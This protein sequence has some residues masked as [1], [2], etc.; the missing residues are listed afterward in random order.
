MVGVARGNGHRAAE[1][2]LDAGLNQVLIAV[3]EYRQ[4]HAGGI[5]VNQLS[6][7]RGPSRRDQSPAD[8]GAAQL[9]ADGGHD[10]G[11]PPT[12]AATIGETVAIG[13]LNARGQDDALELARSEEHTSE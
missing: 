9:G 10:H 2:I 12:G 5:D 4:A 13:S 3:V 11:G 6:W 8:G 7:R 1:R